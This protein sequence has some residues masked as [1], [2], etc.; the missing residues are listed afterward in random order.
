MT[1]D[2]FNPKSW[3]DIEHET[4]M[5]SIRKARLRYYE[6]ECMRFKGVSNDV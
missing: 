3:S 5:E 6:T 2:L 4:Y 1:F